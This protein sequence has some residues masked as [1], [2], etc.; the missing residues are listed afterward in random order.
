MAK[1]KPSSKDQ[2]NRDE[3]KSRKDLDRV[4]PDRSTHR[5]TLK[6][7]AEQLV[8][9]ATALLQISQADEALTVAFKALKRLEKHDDALGLNALPVLNL[10]A[11]INLEIGDADEARKYFSQASQLDPD[12]SIPESLGGGV[13]K[14]L[15]LAQL[16][17]EGGRDSV[18]WFEKAI[19]IL[20]ND[21]TST[22]EPALKAQQSRKLAAALCSVIELYM[23]DLSWEPDAE[24]R[25]ESLI[26]EAILI[27]PESAE[28]LQTLANVRI[29]QERI[30]EAKKA[31]TDSL[32]LWKELP[33]GTENVPD[34]PTRISLARLLMEVG[35]ENDAMEV[36]ERLI[37]EDDTSVEAWYLGGWCAY[38][39]AEQSKSIRG[40]AMTPNGTKGVQDS[41]FDASLVSSRDW[42]KKSLHLY[43]IQDYE[44]DR[45]RDHAMELVRDLDT[46]LGSADDDDE[47]D[48]AENDDWESEFEG[49]DQ[50]MT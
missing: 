43:E 48:A 9:K 6:D 35:M 46:Q 15:W 18:A 38:L 3:R 20:R 11:E 27:A 47:E 19:T 42:L 28:T 17:D 30:D 12:G 22:F 25:C 41:E 4:L 34:F 8:A 14:F 49:E 45:L 50:E 37:E 36:L 44:D 29:S 21:I 24:S 39:T 1:T 5:T 31:L 23:T 2:R 7:S 16:S 10:L 33:S 40:T 32:S 26:T 13:E